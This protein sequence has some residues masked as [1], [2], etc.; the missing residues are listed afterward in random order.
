MNLLFCCGMILFQLISTAQ[1]TISNQLCMMQWQAYNNI[2]RAPVHNAYLLLYNNNYTHV[3][4]NHTLSVTGGS[5]YITTC[6]TS[7]HYNAVVK[8]INNH[9]T[10]GAKS[11]TMSPNQ[12][13]RNINIACE[14]NCKLYHSTQLVGDYIQPDLYY[15]YI[16]FAAVIPIT[17]HVLYKFARRND[18]SESNAI[19]V[20][21]S[22]SFDCDNIIELIDDINATAQVGKLVYEQG[23]RYTWRIEHTKYSVRDALSMLHNTQ[24]INNE[25]NQ[26]VLI[27]QSNLT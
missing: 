4:L 19:S 23:K 16:A 18:M 22:S 6:N 7:I 27:S 24:R 12:P 15:S 25:Q 5:T 14:Q 10:I 3:L 2:D 26:C 8:S 9:Q 13:V 17:M 21:H 20:I 1:Y 11:F